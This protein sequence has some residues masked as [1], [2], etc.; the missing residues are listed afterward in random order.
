MDNPGNSK[1]PTAKNPTATTHDINKEW[2]NLPSETRERIIHRVEAIIRPEL[3]RQER[4]V[5]ERKAKEAEE[6]RDM[7]EG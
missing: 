5:Q 6:A 3:Q 2:K 1:R 7:N 4:N